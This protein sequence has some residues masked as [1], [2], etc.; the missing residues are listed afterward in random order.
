M[1]KELEVINDLK[2]GMS[3]AEASKKHDVSMSMI[4]VYCCRNGMAA[5]RWGNKQS[6]EEVCELHRQGYRRHEISEKL[7][8]KSISS[9]TGIL[10]RNSLTNT[11][12]SQEKID[13]IKSKKNDGVPYS[14]VAKELGL[15]PNIVK[16]F[17]CE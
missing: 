15:S 6:E 13:L 1:S 12:I 9:I 8:G 5:Y 2:A 10:E 3:R 4:S 17:F 16:R 7:N 11:K 14:A